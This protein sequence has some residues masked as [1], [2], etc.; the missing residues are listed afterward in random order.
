MTQ[1]KD[2]YFGFINLGGFSLEKYHT[3]VYFFNVFYVYVPEVF[4][5]L[6]P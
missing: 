5:I 4:Q 1:H 6:C 2:N 3:Y